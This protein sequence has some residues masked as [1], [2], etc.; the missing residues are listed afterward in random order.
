MM[1]SLQ[2]RIR[3]PRAPALALAL[4]AL[5]L[6]ACATTQ[7]KTELAWVA[8]DAQHYPLHR[9][10]ALYVG[11]SAALRHSAEDQMA[12]ELQR[13]G[14]QA[15][16]AYQIL[17]ASDLQDLQRAEGK[18]RAMGYDGIVTMRLVNR[19]QHLNYMPPTFDAY[20]GWASPFFASPAFYGPGI[21]SPGY[22]YTTEEVRMETDAYSLVTG[23]LLWAT[24][25]NT[26]E[27]S[28]TRSLVAHVA[29]KAA[30]D[31]VRN[32]LAV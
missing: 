12:Y 15:T 14:V 16:P 10:V 30:N 7:T 4:C 11:R 13:R 1:A 19:E 31:L 24:I 22:A 25:S 18:L 27:P 21:Y 20:Y 28:S 29:R 9:V 8:P 17:Q 2:T 5:V 6:G 23:R 32:G 3:I 26:S